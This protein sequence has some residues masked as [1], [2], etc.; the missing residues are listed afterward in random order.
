MINYILLFSTIY[1]SQISLSFAAIYGENS[2]LEVEK[3]QNHQI[4]TQA[5]SVAAVFRYYS[6]LERS[7]HQIGKSR[8]LGH[9]MVCEDQDFYHQPIDAIA[10]AFLI[11][12]QHVMSVGHAVTSREDCR[13]GIFFAF[14]YQWSA[15]IHSITP[16]KRSDIYL[17]EDI[18]EFSYTGIDYS[19]IKLDRKVHDI[20]PLKLDFDSEVL[21]REPIYMIGHPMQ[22]PKKMSTG[23]ILRTDKKNPNYYIA[24]IDSFRGS[25]GS[26]VFS[27]Y[28]N[29]VIGILKGGEIDFVVD[30]DR[31]CHQFKTCPE[32]G[33]GCLGESITRLNKL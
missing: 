7:A 16:L 22:L 33:E 20:S 24:A 27:K 9:R 30:E 23:H 14:N 21:E 31:F 26:P 4:K 17:C 19:I 6:D 13:N 8:T 28:S 3:I 32:D 10:T 18:I 29:K 5:K 25:S 11:D 1:T 2:L 12:D 15:E